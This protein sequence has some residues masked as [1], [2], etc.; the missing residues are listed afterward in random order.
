MSDLPTLAEALAALPT[1]ADGIATQ[2]RNKGI[3]GVRTDS[4]NCPITNYLT[5]LGFGLVDVDPGLIEAE[6]G[7]GFEVE[8]T[9]PGISEFIVR[10]DGGEWPE[11]VSDPEAVTRG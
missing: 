8:V 7:D 4:C 2:L 1:T 10:F 6:G 11:L 3:Q 5:S 9:P